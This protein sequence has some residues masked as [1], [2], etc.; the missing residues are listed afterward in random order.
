VTT[1]TRRSPLERVRH[2]RAYIQRIAEETEA[3]V[4]LAS[5]SPGA[6]SEASIRDRALDRALKMFDEIRPVLPALGDSPA[7]DAEREARE[8]LKAELAEL[9]RLILELR[10]GDQG[11]RE[12]RERLIYREQHAGELLCAIRR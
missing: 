4:S 12:T 3:R 9:E 2:A 7:S 11:S 8:A 1:R 10:V 5:A 6:P